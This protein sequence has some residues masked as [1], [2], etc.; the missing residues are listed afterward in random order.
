MQASQSC[1]FSLIDNSLSKN[2][3]HLPI[4]PQRGNSRVKQLPLPYSDFK[5]RLP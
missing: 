5:V 2:F 1:Q 3:P 4:K